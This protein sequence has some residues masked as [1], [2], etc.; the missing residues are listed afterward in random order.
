VESEA[1]LASGPQFKAPGADTGFKKPG[2]LSGSRF[3]PAK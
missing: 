1:P 2:A 3:K